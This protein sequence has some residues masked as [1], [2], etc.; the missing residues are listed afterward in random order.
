MIAPQITW[1]SGFY[2]PQII[3]IS[4]HLTEVNDALLKLFCM[5]SINGGSALYLLLGS[6]IFNKVCGRVKKK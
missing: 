1:L 6:L 2:L 3:I 5:T 4:K